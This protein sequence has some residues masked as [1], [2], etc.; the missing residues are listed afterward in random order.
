RLDW[1]PKL[2]AIHKEIDYC[3]MHEH[4]F[5]E[6][7]CFS[8]QSLDPCPERQMLAFYLSRADFADGMGRSQKVPPVD[9]GRIGVKG[10]HPKGVC[11]VAWCSGIVRICY[12]TF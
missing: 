3:I 12:N 1:S 9:S 11:E 5:R 10:H 2:V 4:G 7:N 8:C 6:T